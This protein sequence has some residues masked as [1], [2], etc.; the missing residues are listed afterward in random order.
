VRWH[1]NRNLIRKHSYIFCSC[2]NKH[3]TYSRNCILILW[4]SMHLWN[5]DVHGHVYKICHPEQLQCYPPRHT[6][7]DYCLVGRDITESGRY[8]STI[9]R[10]MSFTFVEVT[11]ALKVEADTYTE[12]K[13]WHSRRQESSY[14]LMWETQISSSHKVLLRLIL[15]LSY[16]MYIRG[17]P[18][19]PKW[20]PSLNFSNISYASLISRTCATCVAHPMAI[21][22]TNEV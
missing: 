6:C 9:Q 12:Y 16:Y 22:I 10:F 3:N 18:R 4:H 1:G 2:C 14:L 19:S 20:S 11:S 21:V 15:I 5:S 7:E 8:L 17:T 13:A